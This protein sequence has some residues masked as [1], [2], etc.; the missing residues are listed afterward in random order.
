MNA[1]NS[2][3]ALVAAGSNVAKVHGFQ[4]R[5]GFTLI[6]LLVVIAII[7]ILAALLLPA[8][9]GARLR[10][11]QVQCMSNVRQLSQGIYMYHL[12]FGKGVP[13][14]FE[15]AFWV[16]LL[17]GFH[18][19]LE[20][21]LRC[22]ATREPLPEPKRDLEVATAVDGT[23]AN[24]WWWECRT[25]RRDWTGSY[26][27]NGYFCTKKF[28]SPGTAKYHFS[29]FTAL[30]DPATTAVFADGVL[31]LVWVATNRP[32]ANDLFAGNSFYALIARHGNRS[33]NSAP[34]FWPVNQPPPRNWRISVGFADG[35]VE[36][37]KLPDLVALTWHEPIPVG[38]IRP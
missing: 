27:M 29:S 3:S 6:E 4:L 18:P 23:A 5:D 8:L 30:Q 33:P 26:R 20:G 11:H 36:A 17:T 37:I 2:Q 21:V 32:T 28:L 10:A 19:P 16:R 25:P 38:G 35:H 12:D 9:S 13:G 15:D 22:P 24:A 31:P 7:A 34:R 14:Y 1:C